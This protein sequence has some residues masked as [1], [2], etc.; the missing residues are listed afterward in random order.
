MSDVVA[1]M[2][3]SLDGFV[4]GPDDDVMQ[5]FDWYFASGV[6]LDVARAEVPVEH[7]AHPVAG[8]RDEAVERHGHDGDHA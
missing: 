5:V 7:L 8:I 6:D 2:S 3:M 1:I 4:A